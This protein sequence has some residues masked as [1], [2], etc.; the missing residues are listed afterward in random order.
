MRAIR[1]VTLAAITALLALTMTGVVVTETPENRIERLVV[2]LPLPMPEVVI[3]E[4][5]SEGLVWGCY[6]TTPGDES[7]VIILTPQ[8]LE[9]D[10]CAIQRTLAHE[11]LHSS[12]HAS[13]RFVIDENGTVLNGDELEAAAELFENAVTC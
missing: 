12:Q 9:R 13:G 5:A 6:R 2:E 7:G 4:C 11:W 1:C 10:D 8:N 3:G